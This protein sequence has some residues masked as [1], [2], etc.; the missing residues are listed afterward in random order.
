[1]GHFQAGQGHLFVNRLQLRHFPLLATQPHFVDF[2]QKFRDELGGRVGDLKY[3]MGER[4]V[5]EG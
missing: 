3:S 4:G 1:M 2:A 5:S